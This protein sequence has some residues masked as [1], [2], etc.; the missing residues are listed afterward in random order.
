[1]SDTTLPATRRQ[2]LS[3]DV[4]EDDYRKLV[5]LAKSNG[6]TV[7]EEAFHL[8]RMAIDTRI[9][10]KEGFQWIMQVA[11]SPLAIER[12]GCTDGQS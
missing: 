5:E 9:A 4:E 6:W 7:E 3:I 11:D 8:F 12:K 1:M 10:Q 2:H